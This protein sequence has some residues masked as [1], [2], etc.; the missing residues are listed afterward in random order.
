[1]VN[2]IYPEDL[3]KLENKVIIDVREPF[4]YDEMHI[5][6][7]ILIPMYKIPDNIEKIKN[8]NKNIVLVCA[9]GHRSIYVASYLEQNGVK[10]VYNLAGGIYSL[11]FSGFP[12]VTAYDE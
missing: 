11:Y 3:N 12:L 4:E 6:D 8:M 10:N 7:S 2:D 5:K 9:S 1:M